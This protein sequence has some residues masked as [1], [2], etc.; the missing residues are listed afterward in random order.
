MGKA[1]A[2]QARPPVR[3]STASLKKRIHNGLARDLGLA[4]VSGRYLPGESIPGEIAA[5]QEAKVS[6]HVYREAL[7]VL[8]SKGLLESRQKAGT[9]VTPRERWNLLDPEVIEWILADGAQS[10]FRDLLFELRMII[11]PAAAA[12]A[13]ARRSD[14]ELATIQE[15]LLDM[16][17]AEPDSPEGEQADERFHEAILAAGRNEIVA[18]LATIVAASVSFVSE[19]KR[20]RHVERDSWPDHKELFEAIS[21]GDATEAHGAMARLISHARSDVDPSVS[22][23]SSDS[24]PAS[25]L[26]ISKRRAR[27]SS[28]A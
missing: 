14:A 4:I 8:A 20:T 17:A 23:Q 2:V 3:R 10:Q 15:A 16:R 22:E 25:K 19:Y 24:R 28:A 11:E 7:R 18:R 21:V 27:V 9:L 5:S 1:V 6:R 13:A 12:F 26:P